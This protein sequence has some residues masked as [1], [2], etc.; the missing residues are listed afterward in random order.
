MSSNPEHF[1][2]FSSRNLPTQLVLA[3]LTPL[4]QRASSERLPP[5][6]GSALPRPRAHTSRT[7]GPCPAQTDAAPRCGSGTAVPG[8]PAP[9]GDPAAPS[10]GQPLRSG[11]SARTAAATEQPEG[12][13]P[14]AGSGAVPASALGTGRAPRWPLSLPALPASGQG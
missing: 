11:T 12:T 5:A 6:L 8:E 1:T 10:A 7:A 13:V 9:L 3:L 2:A 4:K 14:T